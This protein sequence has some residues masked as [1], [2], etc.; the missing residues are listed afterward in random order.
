MIKNVKIK[1]KKISK[2]KLINIILLEA[3][4]AYL[5][6]LL[7]PTKNSKNVNKTDKIDINN[8]LYSISNNDKLGPQIRFIQNK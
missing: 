6:L 5:F 2:L 8:I 3:K 1:F 4:I 7:H